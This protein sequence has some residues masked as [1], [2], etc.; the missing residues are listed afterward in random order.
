MN[1]SFIE[2]LEKMPGDAMFMKDMVSKK[3]SASFEDDDRMQHC[4]AIATMSLVQ[5]KEDSGAFTISCTIELLH[6][7]K[8]L[9]D[10]GARINLMP[11]FIY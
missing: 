1:I 5:K 6:F 10:L 2:T 11:L 4:S 9:C 7:S 8:E 3:R